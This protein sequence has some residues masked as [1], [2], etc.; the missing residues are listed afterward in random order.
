MDGQKD[1]QV[2]RQTDK[3]TETERQTERQKRGLVRVFE[4]LKP[5][6]SDTSS[7]KAI[8]LNPP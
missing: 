2:D 7:N 8:P 3:Q 4:T 5:I 6:P 1:R